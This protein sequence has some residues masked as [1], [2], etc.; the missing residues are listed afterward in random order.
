MSKVYIEH[1][2]RH[3]EPRI[4]TFATQ[5]A[6]LDSLTHYNP[7]DREI[8]ERDLFDPDEGSGEY[9]D[10]SDKYAVVT[11]EI[12]RG[13]SSYWDDVAEAIRAGKDAPP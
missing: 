7:E 11:E 12:A 1:D 4:L 5:D 8:A 6:A 3:N 2:D 9:H 10:G 13:R